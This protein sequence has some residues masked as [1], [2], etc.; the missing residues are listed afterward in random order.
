MM[1]SVSAV[2]SLEDIEQRE[3]N[4]AIQSQAAREMCEFDTAEYNVELDKLIDS[5][6]VHNEVVAEFGQ[7]AETIELYDRMEE[8]VLVIDT[9]YKMLDAICPKDMMTDVV[10][11]ADELTK[12]NEK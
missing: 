9:K 5:L 1:G 3:R 10:T 6:I 7:S 12:F 8:A 4:A 11:V 2:L